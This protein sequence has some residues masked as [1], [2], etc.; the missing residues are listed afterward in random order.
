ML[1]KSPKK[2]LTYGGVMT[3][4]SKRISDRTL[5]SDP[6]SGTMSTGDLHEEPLVN[7]RWIQ[8]FLSSTQQA[9]VRILSEPSGTSKW[10]EI[11]RPACSLQP[12]LGPVDVRVLVSLTTR[13]YQLQVLYPIPRVGVVERFKGN[14]MCLCNV[15]SPY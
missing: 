15:H 2:C 14:C 12:P 13:V 10:L 7:E 11:T 8:A 5:E 3:D 1:A 9:K 4:K 6:V